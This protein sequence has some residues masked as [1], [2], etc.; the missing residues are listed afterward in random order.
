MLNCLTES[1]TSFSLDERVELFGTILSDQLDVLV[2]LQ[3]SN[4]AATDAIAIVDVG[5]SDRV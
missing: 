3:E 1:M 5:D 2:V 4:M